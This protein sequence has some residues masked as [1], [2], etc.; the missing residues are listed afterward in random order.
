MK[1]GKHEDS[2]IQNFLYNIAWL[3]KH[4]HLTKKKMAALLGI[5]I[6]SLIKIENGRLPKK[7]TIEAVEKIYFNFGI[8]PE[9]QFSRKFGEQGD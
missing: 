6:F 3:R 4:H 5:G 9:E 1:K 2:K 8:D 7:L